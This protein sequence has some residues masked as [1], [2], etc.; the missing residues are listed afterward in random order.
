MFRKNERGRERERK[1]KRRKEQKGKMLDWKA[2]PNTGKQ[3][4][5]KMLTFHLPTYSVV[6]EGFRKEF[7]MPAGLHSWIYARLGGCVEPSVSPPC[8]HSLHEFSLW[9]PLASSS[10]A[11]LGGLLDVQCPEVAAS[12][13]RSAPG[14]NQTSLAVPLPPCLMKWVGS[15]QSTVRFWV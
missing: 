14:A 6:E 8:T 11:N 13:L 15:N 12:F 3:K 9:T 4:L 5:Q 10:S 2:W 1:K 7:Q